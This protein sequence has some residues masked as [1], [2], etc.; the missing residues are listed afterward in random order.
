MAAER[1]AKRDDIDRQKQAEIDR[2]EAE[3]AAIEPLEILV[4][5]G[6]PRSGTSLMMQMLKAGGIDPMTD[7]KRTADDDNPEGYWEWEEVKQLP[8]NPRL[9]ERTEGKAVKVISALLPTLPR[10]HRYKIIYMVRP[11]TQVVDSQLVML[12][13][14]GQKARSEKQH[15]IEV[16][17]AHSRQIRQVLAKSDR[18]ELLEVSYPDL[19]ADP[20]PV[21]EQLKTFLGERFQVSESVA[22]CVK[23]KLFRNR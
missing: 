8:K 9:I 19:V 4:V 1:K 22:V 7:G 5:S 12:D 18:V 21:I 10:P 13:R 11:T 16:Q 2:V 6:L 3:I 15:L 20:G 23:P 17:E 14:Q